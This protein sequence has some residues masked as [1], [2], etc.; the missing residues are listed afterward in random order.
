MSTSEIEEPFL[1]VDFGKEGGRHRWQTI[2]EVE[3]WH[4]AIINAWQWL[5]ASGSHAERVAWDSLTSGLSKPMSTLRQAQSYKVNNQHGNYTVHR[6]AAKTQLEEFIGKRPWVL[7]MSARAKFVFGLN[8]EG[9]TTEAAVITAYWLGH[10]IQS[11]PL[12]STIPALLTLE[13]FERGIKKRL[14]GEQEALSELAGDMRTAV[15][16]IKIAQGQQ[17]GAFSKQH[18][19][20]QTQMGEQQKAFDDVQGERDTAW[21]KLVNAS[22]AELQAIAKTYDDHMAMAA[23]VAYWKAKRKRHAIWMVISGTLL[24]LSMVLSGLFLHSEIQ[25]IGRAAAAQS[26]KSAS[27]STP[28]A[29]SSSSASSTSPTTQTHTA[30]VV[31]QVGIAVEAAAAWGIGSFIILA[32]LCF[33]FLRILVKIFLSNMHLENDAAERVTM[34]QTYLALLR[35][36]KLPDKDNI[37]TVLAALFRPSGD[38]IVKDEGVPPTTL[39]W[40]TRLGKGN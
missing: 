10:D 27:L 21:S 28:A 29:Q 31:A 30:S 25:A 13:F 2:A 32:T 11:M 40:F 12:R 7:P 8:N 36:N 23:P 19:D 14:D 18:G 26:T 6:D 1:E 24:A 33:W 35:K 20:L 38:G 3:T 22:N 37:S 39:E 15:N 34:A 4:S 9:K 17:A 16:D 5:N